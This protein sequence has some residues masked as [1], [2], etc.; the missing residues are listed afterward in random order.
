M[1]FGTAARRAVGMAKPFLDKGIA[2]GKAALGKGKAAITEAGIPTMAT[3]AAVG[4][5][6][7]AGVSGMMSSAARAKEV[8]LLQKRIRQLQEELAAEK[9]SK[10]RRELQERLAPLLAQM[11]EM[12]QQ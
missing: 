9:N 4:T 5:V 1:G 2:V 6:V 7:G 11:E 10:A 3:E 12:S 8:A